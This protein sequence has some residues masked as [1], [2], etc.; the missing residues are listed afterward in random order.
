MAFWNANMFVIKWDLYSKAYWWPV[1]D[2]HKKQKEAYIFV[3]SVNLKY[4]ML[5]ESDFP[6]LVSGFWVHI[7]TCAH[8]KSINPAL[9]FKLHLIFCFVQLNY[10]EM[11]K[12]FFF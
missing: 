6:N 8:S 12:C 2:L 11:Q 10:V 5:I 3:V 1:F 4:E 7:V 9:H